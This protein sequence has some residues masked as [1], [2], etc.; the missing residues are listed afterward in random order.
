MSKNVKQYA[1]S[2]YWA[3]YKQEEIIKKLSI[4]KNKLSEFITVFIDEKRQVHSNYHAIRVEYLKGLEHELFEAIQNK[5]SKSYIDEL[6]RNYV[7]FLL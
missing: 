5:Q 6:Q 3:G 4:N 7:N 1:R 2:M